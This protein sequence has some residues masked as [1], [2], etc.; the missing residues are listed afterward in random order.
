MRSSRY[1]RCS[2][3]TPAVASRYCCSGSTT[4]SRRRLLDPQKKNRRG[5]KYGGDEIDENREEKGAEQLTQFQL[6]APPLSKTTEKNDVQ[7]RFFFRFC[8][9]C[10]F[11]FYLNRVSLSI[12][13]N[14]SCWFIFSCGFRINFVEFC[15]SR[16]YDV[17]R[18]RDKT[19]DSL[20]CEAF[21]MAIIR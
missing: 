14:F 4:R 17:Q 6:L 3:L 15:Q 7:S 12:R 16:V 2:L 9:N 21:A 19:C 8:L 13:F 10:L 1:P 5:N 18:H 11:F 20:I